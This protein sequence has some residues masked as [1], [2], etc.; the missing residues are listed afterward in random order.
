MI[1]APDTPALYVRYYLPVP[2][3]LVLGFG[4]LDYRLAEEG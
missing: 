1:Q 2:S 4:Y 3:R